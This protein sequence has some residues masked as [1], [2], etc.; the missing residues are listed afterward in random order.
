MIVVT[1]FKELNKN[2]LRGTFSV[3]F[4][5]WGGLIIEDFCL[6]EKDSKQWIS[7]P[8]KVHFDEKGEKKYIPF[9]YFDDRKMMDAFQ[10]KL[11]TALDEYFKNNT[12][13][14]P[15]VYHEEENPPF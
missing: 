14:N 13:Q 9:A 11:L 12:L 3:R 7:F 8:K 15:S 1:N 2:S 5:K 10:E 6:F 4:Q